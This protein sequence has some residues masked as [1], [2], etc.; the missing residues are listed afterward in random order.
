MFARRGD[1]PFFLLT[2][3]PVGLMGVFRA[4][5]RSPFSGSGE[6]ENRPFSERGPPENLRISRSR[7][8]GSQRVFVWGARWG[9]WAVLASLL[10]PSVIRVTLSCVGCVCSIQ[11]G[12]GAERRG[13]PIACDQPGV[14]SL[15][16]PPRNKCYGARKLR[17]KC[18][19]AA[20]RSLDMA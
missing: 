14:H 19:E 2:F 6:S 10:A 15:S 11:A 7:L 16:L 17:I 20:R 13:A 4:Y 12:T 5:R 1:G 9:A 8:R 18:D 3:S